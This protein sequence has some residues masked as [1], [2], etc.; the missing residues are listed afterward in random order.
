MRNWR[1]GRGKIDRSDVERH[2]PEMR[3][4]IAATVDARA[5]HALSPVLV[6]NAELCPVAT[7][8][9]NR[10]ALEPENVIVRAG[11]RGQSRG[12]CSW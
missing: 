11:R 9:G 8:E 12:A 6:K 2:I 1:R 10:L 5:F 7:P 4:A 3:Q